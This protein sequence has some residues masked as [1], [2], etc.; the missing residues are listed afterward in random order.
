MSVESAPIPVEEGL[1]V[2][3][4]RTTP[5][6]AQVKGT[7]LYAPGAGS[8]VNDP[9]GIYLSQRLAE[10]GWKT[11]RFQFPYMEAGKRRPDSPRLLEE[12]WRRVIESVGSQGSPLIVGGR[13]MGGRIASQVV[14][15][16]TTV[17]GLALFAYPLSPPRSSSKPP[18]KRRDEHLP[19]IAVPTLFCSGTRDAFATPD[20]LREAAALAPM[21]TVRLLDGADHGFAVLK[22]SG[23]AKEDIWSEATGHF[24]DWLASRA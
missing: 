22:S 4:V 11:V 2:T 5:D 20:Q 10:S 23:R 18:A 19:D 6:N 16:G 1:S 14:A 12:T 7:F 13:S 21:S 24:L 3:A 17:D 9:F 8:N 15:Q